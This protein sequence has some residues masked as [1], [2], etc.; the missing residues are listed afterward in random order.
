[1]PVALAGGYSASNVGVGTVLHKETLGAGGRVVL[2]LSGYSMFD[3]G[4][5]RNYT[6]RTNSVTG[7]VRIALRF[8]ETNI[9]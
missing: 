5:G 6:I 8:R 7:I 3:E 4:T 1:M 9:K 2:D